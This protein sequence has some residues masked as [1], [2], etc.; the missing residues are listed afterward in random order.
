MKKYVLVSDGSSDRALLNI[1]NHCL[2]K[3]FNH[4][5]DGTRAELGRIGVEK[6][7]SL[8]KKI[9]VA[10]EWYEPHFVVVHRDAE[11]QGIQKRIEEIEV[12][13]SQLAGSQMSF[14]KI[15]PI[16]MTEAWLLIDEMAIR[17]A[18]GNP[19]GKMPLQLPAIDKLETLSN[20]KEILQGLIKEAS[21]LS[22]RRLRDMN[23][24]QSIQ[25]IPEFLTNFDPL[26]GLESYRHF[27]G[28]VNK[29]QF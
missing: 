19:N 12:A 25:L 4:T 17:R 15:I 26:N 10:I 8:A 22:G 24:Q 7:K 6:T 14:V 3:N 9:T 28:E 29:L 18:A 1:I 16:K 23:V 20:P 11:N 13:V 5:F 21:G 27:Q 2:E